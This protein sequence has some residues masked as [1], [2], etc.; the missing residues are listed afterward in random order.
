MRK[1]PMSS[2]TLYNQNTN[3][4]PLPVTLAITFHQLYPLVDFVYS[5]AKGIFT[6]Q[7]RN[8]PVHEGKC[9]CPDCGKGVVFEWVVIKCS[10]CHKKRPSQSLMNRMYPSQRCCLLCGD[11]ETYTEALDNP[12]YFQL[13]QAQL[14][15]KDEGDN[16]SHF[17]NWTHVWVEPVFKGMLPVGS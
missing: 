10:G 4:R 14:L 9:Y 8:I 5:L 6:C 17:E 15:F 3:P 13:N 12:W 16:Q 2:Q 11:T 1:H 7:H